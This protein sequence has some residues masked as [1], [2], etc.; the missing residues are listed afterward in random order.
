MSEMQVEFSDKIEASVD[1]A[2]DFNTL[3]TKYGKKN[4]KKLTCRP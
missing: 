2:Q 3:G 1:F 4:L